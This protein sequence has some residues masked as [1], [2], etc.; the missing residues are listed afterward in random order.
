MYTPQKLLSD[1]SKTDISIN[2]PILGH[3]KP[4]KTCFACCYAKVG[5]INW[6]NSR[7]KQVYVSK[8]LSGGDISQL[9]TECQKYNAV[10]LSGTGDLLPCHVKNILALAE[11]DPGTQFWGMTRKLD[12]ARSINGRLPNLKLLVS[13]DATSPESTWQYEGKLCYGPRKEGDEVPKDDNRIVTIFPYHFIGKTV[14]KIV[15]DKRNCPAVLH[16]IK[17]CHQCGQCWS[18]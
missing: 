5:P 9:K 17:G 10:R 18:W 16:H 15:K 2:L 6:S 1:N 3:C 7:R 14:G 13:V 4:T 8:Y 11:M 12:I